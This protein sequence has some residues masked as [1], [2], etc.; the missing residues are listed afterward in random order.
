MQENETNIEQFMDEVFQKLN[1]L[2]GEPEWKQKIYNMVRR[3]IM[4]YTA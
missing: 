4:E 3:I 2:E 1:R